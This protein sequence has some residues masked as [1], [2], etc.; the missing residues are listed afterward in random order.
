MSEEH[1]TS[2]GATLG[3]VAYMSPEHARAR[4]LDARTDLF[5]FGAVLYEMVALSRGRH[6]D[7]FRRYPEP[8]A[9]CSST[10]EC[11][12]NRSNELVNKL[13]EGWELSERH[14]L[15]GIDAGTVSRTRLRA[16]RF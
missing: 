7:D 11:R 10:T 1:L 3:T 6:N 4:E 5:S 14:L 9:G 15:A 16:N 2:L 12:L 13:L 8:P